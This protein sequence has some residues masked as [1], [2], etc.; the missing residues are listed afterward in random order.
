MSFEHLPLPELAFWR[1]FLGKYAQMLS[2]GAFFTSK[3]GA[4]APPGGDLEGTKKRPDLE[5]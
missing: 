5:F 3:L 1:R 4:Q 2:S